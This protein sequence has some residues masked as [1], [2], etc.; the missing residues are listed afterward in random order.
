MWEAVVD[1]APEVS[2]GAGGAIVQFRLARLQ[3]LLQHQTVLRMSAPDMRECRVRNRTAI[4]VIPTM[5]AS[6]LSAAAIPCQTCR[7]QE[8]VVAVSINS[9]LLW[10]A[11]LANQRRC[12]CPTQ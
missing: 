9:R 3:T 6:G 4:G 8:S 10:W 1:L 5:V 11:L 7:E 2:F 12:A